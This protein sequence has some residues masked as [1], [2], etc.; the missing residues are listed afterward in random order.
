[1]L[2]E[3]ST[4]YWTTLSINMD[5]QLV[6]G[7]ERMSMGSNCC[8][9]V[10]SSETSFADGRAMSGQKVSRLPEGALLG[11]PVTASLAFLLALAVEV[12]GSVSGRGVGAG[13]WCGA[14]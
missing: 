11:V 6:S 13:V 4:A 2:A 14:T 12:R 9:G 8:A 1:M 3:T 5:I 7:V 10:V